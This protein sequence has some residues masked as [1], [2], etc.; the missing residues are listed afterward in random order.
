MQV[1]DAVG[2]HE[3]TQFSGSFFMPSHCE[4]LAAALRDPSSP[5]GAAV[6]S[7]RDKGMPLKVAVHDQTTGQVYVADDNGDLEI[8][9]G[10]IREMV[11]GEPWRDPGSLNPVLPAAVLQSPT[12]LAAHEADMRN[13]WLYLVRFYRPQFGN[14]PRLNA[15]ANDAITRLRTPHFQQGLA[16]LA[17]NYERWDAIIGA[18]ID[19]LDEIHGEGDAAN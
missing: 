18:S 5:F 7:M 3:Q 16:A 2:R 1:F 19:T 6:Q 9:H 4:N 8:A 11:T 10:A 13:M 15:Y 12:R 14:L 17:D